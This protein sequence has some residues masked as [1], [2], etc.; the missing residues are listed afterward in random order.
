MAVFRP[1]AGYF[2]L[3]AATNFT[4]AFSRTSGVGGTATD[5]PVL[6]R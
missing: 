1:S 6:G 4:T 2:I 3:Q 5:L